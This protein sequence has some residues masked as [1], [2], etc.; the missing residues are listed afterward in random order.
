LL[1]PWELVVECGVLVE[2]LK[3][4]LAETCAVVVVLMV[5]PALDEAALVF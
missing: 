1:L 5:W 3:P 4:E 2:E